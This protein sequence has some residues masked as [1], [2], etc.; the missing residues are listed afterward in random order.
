MSD[1]PQAPTAASAHNAAHCGAAFGALR[2]TSASTQDAS[3]SAV[4]G[5]V[6]VDRVAAQWTWAGHWVTTSPMISPEQQRTADVDDGGA[7]RIGRADQPPIR[8]S[9]TSC[10]AAPSPPARQTSSA[11]TAVTTY[12]SRRP[13]LG[14]DA[15]GTA[16]SRPLRRP[17]PASPFPAHIRRPCRDGQRPRGL[18]RW[19]ARCRW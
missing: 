17:H 19:R 10:K 16:R 9:R 1:H 4:S 18:C 8:P 7:H 3:S 13:G 2:R 6:V 5:W 11:V 14:G 15:R 12:S